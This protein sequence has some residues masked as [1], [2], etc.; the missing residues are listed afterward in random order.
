MAW[1]LCTGCVLSY[2]IPGIGL[3]EECH[4]DNLRRQAVEAD[5]DR[6][7]KRRAWW[8][9]KQ[10]KHRDAERLRPLELLDEGADPLRVGAEVVDV[11]LRLKGSSHDARTTALI[12]QAIESVKQLAW[13][14]EPELV[15]RGRKR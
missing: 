13:G 15:E 4:R 11:L 14:P 8:R 3:C 9:D 6:G 5:L 1:Q 7:D 2:Q 12:D 10:R